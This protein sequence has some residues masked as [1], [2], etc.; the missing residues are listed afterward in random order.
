MSKRRERTPEQV[1][2]DRAEW[3]KVGQTPLR[4]TPPTGGSFED[5]MAADPARRAQI[6]AGR[7]KEAMINGKAEYRPDRATA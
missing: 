7:K 3:T 5:Y 4:E 6:E 1:A 2:E